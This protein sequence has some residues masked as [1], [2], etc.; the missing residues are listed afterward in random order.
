MVTDCKKLTKFLKDKLKD[1]VEIEW[2]DFSFTEDG[3]PTSEI[4]TALIGPWFCIKILVNYK[5]RTT[6]PSTSR[7][8]GDPE[9]VHAW[10]SWIGLNET[11]PES[12]QNP[13]ELEEWAHLSTYYRITFRDVQ[14]PGPFGTHEGRM[15]KDITPEGIVE[16]YV[17]TEKRFQ[18]EAPISKVKEEIVDL[19]IIQKN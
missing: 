16:L 14:Y 2:S 11:A 17:V 12:A 6:D 4:I 9:D 3:P 7:A 13:E 19:N 5:G 18:D 8:L 15:V 10:Y 1:E